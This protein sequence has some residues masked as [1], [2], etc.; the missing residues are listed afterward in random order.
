MAYTLKP[1]EVG[2]F[3]IGGLREIGKIPT[4]LSTKMRLLLS[5]LGLNSQR[6]IYLVSTMLSLTTL[7][8]LKILTAS[9]LS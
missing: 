9:K 7:I 4:V 2:V 1:E 3:A 5:M 8:L 6:T